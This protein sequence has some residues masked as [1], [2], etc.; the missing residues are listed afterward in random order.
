MRSF[1]TIKHFWNMSNIKN[2]SLSLTSQYCVKK[3][4][5]FWTT[6]MNPATFLSM[7]PFIKSFHW[8]C[9]TK[10]RSHHNIIFEYMNEK[11]KLHRLQKTK[12]TGQQVV[13]EPRDWQLRET[14]L[15]NSFSSA[16]R[17]CP[18]ATLVHSVPLPWHPITDRCRLSPFNLGRAVTTTSLS[19]IQMCNW[20][21]YF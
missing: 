19:Y 7:F 20:V 12:K 13:K 11:F 5:S 15:S 2:I 17:R 10:I 6:E 14:R 8:T 1:Q 9:S 21:K 3:F 4:K 18:G 16:E